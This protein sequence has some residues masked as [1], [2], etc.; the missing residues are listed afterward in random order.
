MIDSIETFKVAPGKYRQAREWGAKMMEYAKKNFPVWQFSLLQPISGEVE[1]IVLVVQGPSL[2][3]Y[4]ED[5]NRRI[6]DPEWE[7]IT[8]ELWESDWFL[9]FS[10][11][12]FDVVE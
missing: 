6:S 8:K 7:P 3:E 2:S 11:R 5:R 4:E 9:G 1:E 12:L 10:R